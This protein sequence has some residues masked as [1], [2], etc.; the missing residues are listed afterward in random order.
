[1]AK[2]EALV[3]RARKTSW[4]TSPARSGADLAQGGGIDEVGVPS[5]DFAERGLGSV[6][7]VVAEQLGVGHILHL[8][9]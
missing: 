9:Y 2:G 7:G 6:F 3:A 1:M 8:T 5:D 4:E